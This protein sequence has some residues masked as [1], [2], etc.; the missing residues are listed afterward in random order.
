VREERERIISF[1]RD[2]EIGNV[3]WEVGDVQDASGKR[4]A[5]T[6]VEE[7][8]YNNARTTL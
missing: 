6:K 8:G 2:S 5:T 4:H 3:E 7:G 1:V